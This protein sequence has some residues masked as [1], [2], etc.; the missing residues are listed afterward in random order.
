MRGLRSVLPR[1]ND[2][3]MQLSRNIV[4]KLSLLSRVQSRQVTAKRSAA[5]AQPKKKLAQ[6]KIA[7]IFVNLLYMPGISKGI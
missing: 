1:M 2:N 5:G 4:R 7:L 3:W 6:I